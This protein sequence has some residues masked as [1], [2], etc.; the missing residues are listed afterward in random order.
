MKPKLTAIINGEILSTHHG[1]DG[2]GFQINWDGEP[3]WVWDNRPHPDAFPSELIG[4][5]R[6]V[7]VSIESWGV[8]FVGFIN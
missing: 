7:K 8:K 1:S 4:K 2:F 5:K 6:K 3:T